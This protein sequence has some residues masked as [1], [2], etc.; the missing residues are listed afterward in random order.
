[1]SRTCYDL[2]SMNT[3]MQ[4]RVAQTV[5]QDADFC[6]QCNTCN[7]WRGINLLA[8]ND[9]CMESGL[10]GWLQITVQ[11]LLYPK[12]LVNATFGSGKKSC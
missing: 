3:L 4:H 6:R 10:G 7:A 12:S 1:M 11:N 5:A 2:V 9:I 8:F